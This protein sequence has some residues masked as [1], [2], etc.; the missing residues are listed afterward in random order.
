MRA[1]KAPKVCSPVEEAIN[2]R[3]FVAIEEL[4]LLG[5]LS[6]LESFC[7]EAG[8]SASRYREM[9]ATYGVAPRPDHVSRY[10]S[11]QIEAVY[12]LTTKYGVSANWL[13]T[14]RGKILK[15]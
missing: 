4:V 14:G 7:K 1:N 9:R 2:K 12:T 10:K 15:A 3:F 8:L 13:I 11:L 5:R 6:A